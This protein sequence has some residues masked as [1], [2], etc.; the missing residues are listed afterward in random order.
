GAGKSTLMRILEGEHPPDGGTIA[1]DGRP[2]TISSTR[3]AHAMGIRV[4]HQ[5]PEIIPELTVA[6]NIFIGD[7]RPRGGVF[8]DR[9]A[10]E[11]RAAAMLADFGLTAALAPGRPCRNLGPAQRQIIEILRA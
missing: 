5:E 7:L 4:I 8:L 11:R 2:V 6:E 10:L 1:I 9:P 3:D